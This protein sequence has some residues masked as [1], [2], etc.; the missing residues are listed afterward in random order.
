M[1]A[2]AQQTDKNNAKP[3]LRLNWLAARKREKVTT[4]K[5]DSH[6]IWRLQIIQA[7]VTSL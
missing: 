6:Q 1:T 7:T 3:Q 5:G 2:F 4:R